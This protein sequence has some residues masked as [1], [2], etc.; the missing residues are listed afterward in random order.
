LHPAEPGSSGAH[1]SQQIGWVL[2][3]AFYVDSFAPLELLNIG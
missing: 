2:Q 1:E 3:A